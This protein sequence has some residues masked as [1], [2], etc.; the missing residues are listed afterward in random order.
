MFF[1]D[2][3][4]E[5][6]FYEKVPFLIHS[7]VAGETPLHLMEADYEGAKHPTYQFIGGGDTNPKTAKHPE[8]EQTYLGTVLHLEPYLYSAAGHG[9]QT[10]PFATAIYRVHLR[11]LSPEALQKAM[12]APGF[13]QDEEGYKITVKELRRTGM[14]EIGYQLLPPEK[15]ES[16][17]PQIKVRLP[18]ASLKDWEDRTKDIVINMK[19]IISTQLV[20]GCAQGCLNTAGNPAVAL[21]KV[22]ARRR[23][24]ELLKTDPNQVLVKIMMD[25]FR[26]S[27]SARKQGH[28]PVVRLNATSDEY[29]EQPAY[30]LPSDP[31]KLKELFSDHLPKRLVAD[32]ASHIGGVVGATDRKEVYEKLAQHAAG[33][34]LLELFPD[35]QFYDYTKDPSRV[36]KFLRS[37][38]GGEQQ[39]P[40]NYHLTFSLAEDNR[41]MARKILQSGGTVAAVFNVATSHKK[42]GELP[43]TFM[44]FPVHDAD[45]HDYRF[46]DKP[47]TVAGLRAKGAAQDPTINYGFVIEPDDPELDQSDPAV[48]AAH[49]YFKSK[50]ERIRSGKLRG[51]STQI[52]TYRAAAAKMGLP[53][54]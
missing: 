14:G 5:S 25:L 15:R 34:T 1:R 44:G 13:E 41:E 23:R 22:S 6:E 52:G 37:R 9:S 4:A 50:L 28:Q 11:S 51:A 47:G 42:K 3:M 26:L 49:P 39:W 54:I 35:V 8:T 18:G 27:N 31:Q 40:K 48:V 36:M 7:D 17:P 53:V 12:A 38:S 2:F 20:G 16:C 10:C 29:W 45:T 43:K 19:D 30:K 24:T 33:K 46:L 21:E 32:L